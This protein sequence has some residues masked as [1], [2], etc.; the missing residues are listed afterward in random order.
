MAKATS[1]FLFVQVL[2]L[3]R[4]V[5]NMSSHLT[6]TLQVLKGNKPPRLL[7]QRKPKTRKGVKY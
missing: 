3:D 6:L 2:L 5:G 4:P 7:P 1:S